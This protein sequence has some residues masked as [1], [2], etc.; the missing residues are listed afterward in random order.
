MMTNH[1]IPVRRH[2]HETGE[3]EHRVRSAETA[4]QERA[5]AGQPQADN[6]GDPVTNAAGP[7]GAAELSTDAAPRGGTLPVAGAASDSDMAPGG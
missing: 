3:T 7:Q 6:S 2:S 1:T 4:R 5:Q